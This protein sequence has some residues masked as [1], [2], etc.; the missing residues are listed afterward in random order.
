[1]CFSSLIIHYGFIKENESFY[2]HGKKENPMDVKNFEMA[3][4]HKGEVVYAVSASGVV[5]FT[6]TSVAG[7]LTS[8]LPVGTVFSNQ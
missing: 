1:M 8:Y 3:K 4:V 2:F 6:V 5:T 7:D